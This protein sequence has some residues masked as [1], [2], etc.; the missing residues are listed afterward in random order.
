MSLPFSTFDFTAQIVDGDSE[1]LLV[2]DLETRLLASI[3]R[4]HVSID[5]VFLRNYKMDDSYIDADAS[6][7]PFVQ[8]LAAII[9]DQAQNS[10]S[11]QARVFEEWDFEYSE[12][13]YIVQN[14][15]KR[16]DVL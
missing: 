3:Y 7:D 4:N 14:R 9:R 2:P 1:A 8:R 5:T 16:H 11:F 6:L 15:L 12:D 10:D 13:P